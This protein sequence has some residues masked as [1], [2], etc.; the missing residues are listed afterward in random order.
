MR[1]TFPPW[2]LRLSIFGVLLGLIF[3]S[4][5]RDKAKAYVD[6]SCE[7][8]YSFCTYNC[9]VACQ[10]DPA[11]YASCRAG[12]QLN[13]NTCETCE[14]HNFPPG[15]MDGVDIPEPYPVFADFSMCM[16]DCN[17]SCNWLP[18]AERSACFVPCKANCIA[19]YA[20]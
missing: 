11:C 17:S 9:A 20:N 6:Y 7:N 19:L 1:K 4:S 15:C 12:C 18:L 2:P 10:A 8:Q 16:D 13:N 3:I 5:S 14:T